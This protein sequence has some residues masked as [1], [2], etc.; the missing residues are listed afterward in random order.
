MSSAT[1]KRDREAMGM[2]LS[3]AGQLGYLIALPAFAFGFGGAYMDKAYGT[4]PMYMLLGL[5]IALILSSI[6]VYRKV[7][8]I[9][10]SFPPA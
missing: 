9:I 1:V 4:S 10:S 7:K 5:F 8:A 6:A 3:L 2:S